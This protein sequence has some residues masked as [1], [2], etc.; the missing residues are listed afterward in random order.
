MRNWQLRRLLYLGKLPGSLRSDHQNT[1]QRPTDLHRKL[2]STGETHPKE[3]VGLAVGE[4]GKRI[5]EAQPSH[6][7]A[8][9]SDACKRMSSTGTHIR[10]ELE[11]SLE[12]AY[13]KFCFLEQ[14]G[15]DLTALHGKPRR[16]NGNSRPAC[17]SCSRSRNLHSPRGW[18]NCS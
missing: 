2:P 12:K 3:S 1:V 13:Y 4:G 17:S 11:E 15:N 6:C 7:P 18:C 16:G 14:T 9:P 5:K 8:D 10:F